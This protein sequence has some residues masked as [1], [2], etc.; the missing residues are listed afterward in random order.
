MFKE[1]LISN[2]KIGNL[3]SEGAIISKIPAQDLVN[4]NFFFIPI[5]DYGNDLFYRHIKYVDNISAFTKDAIQITNIKGNRGDMQMQ[6]K[7]FGYSR[8]NVGNFRTKL[9]LFF[10]LF[11]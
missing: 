5:Q 6:M 2:L 3:K 4:P 10:I 8:T 9:D 11:Q 7:P 1:Y